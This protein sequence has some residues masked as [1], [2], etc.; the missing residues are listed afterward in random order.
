MW[1]MDGW[2]AIEVGV[3][4]LQQRWITGRASELGVDW[5]IDEKHHLS[6]SQGGAISPCVFFVFECLFTKKNMTKRGNLY[7]GYFFK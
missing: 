4:H 2:T 1:R 5:D 3:F 7:K 6:E